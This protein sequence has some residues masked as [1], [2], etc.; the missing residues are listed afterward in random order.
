MKGRF[1][2]LFIIIFL[3]L[4]FFNICS[5]SSVEVPIQSFE[6]TW[7][8]TTT[9]AWWSRVTDRAYHW[10]YSLYANN[11][12]LL[13]LAWS[14]CFSITAN[15]LSTQT[16]ISFHTYLDIL[17]ELFDILFWI[18]INNYL[19]FSIDGV[20][21]ARWA[22]TTWWAKS[23]FNVTPWNHTFRWCNIRSL[24]ALSSIAYVDYITLKT[25]LSTLQQV[26][27]ILS[28]TNDNTPNYTFYSPVAWNI[29]YWW[30]C[31]SATQNASIWNNTITLNS[32]AD[33][34]YNNC[35]IT[36]YQNW[37][38]ITYPLTIS[39]FTIDTTQPNISII[40][41]SLWN[42]SPSANLPL[43]LSYNDVTSWIN[44]NS[45]TITLQK[46]NWTSWWTNISWTYINISNKTYSNASWTIQK[47]QY[48]K[49]LLTSSITDLAGNNK[50]IT[51][52]FYIDEP[53]LIIS[54]SLVD[55]GKLVNW[56]NK[57]S[58]DLTLTVKTVWAPFNL[59]LNKEGNIVYSNVEIAP[60]NGVTWFWYDKTPY[61]NNIKLINT[62]EVIATQNASINTN[63]QKN[64]Y[65]YSL[66][67]WANVNNTQ[68]WGN[69]EGLIK[70]TLQLS[71]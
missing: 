69:Y 28:I 53:E 38:G 21:Q 56:T 47:L 22:G 57:F 32:L 25:N 30:S 59:I 17:P 31:S 71:Y 2:K 5:S 23:T 6:T 13:S 51:S 60:W 7:W 63:W 64:V 35:T 33:W 12:W 52:T 68:A 50:T 26:T 55:I 43:N 36:V 3:N 58:P 49:Y 61:T 34:T 20:E 70:F 62:N 4:I 14:A 66:K 54:N 24:L 8:Y 27:P 41:P 46:W 11:D 65:N 48:W 16:Q 15:V 18:L 29:V 37:V 45:L 1:L 67:F 10:S 39:S 42:L 9:W 40:N 44:T 19:V